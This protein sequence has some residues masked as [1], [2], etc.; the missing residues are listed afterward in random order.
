MRAPRCPHLRQRSII[1]GQFLGIATLVCASAFAALL[2]LA[3]PP[4]WTAL[5]GVVPLALGLQRLVALARDDNGA[6]EE[7]RAKS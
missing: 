6:S 1:V 3:V 5:L 7:R 4:G 2:A